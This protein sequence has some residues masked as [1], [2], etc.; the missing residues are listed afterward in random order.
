MPILRYLSMACAYRFARVC[1]SEKDLFTPLPDRGSHTLRINPAM[2][3]A[4]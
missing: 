4:I 2:L 1:W 3:R